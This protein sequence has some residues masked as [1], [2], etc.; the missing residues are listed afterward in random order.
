[1]KIKLNISLAL[2]FGILLAGLFVSASPV[3]A[4]ALKIDTVLVKVLGTGEDARYEPR[5]LQI[6]RGDVIRF[7]VEEGIHTVTAYHP[8]NRRSLRIPAEAESFDSGPLQAGSV[9]FL[10]LKKEGTYD[11]FCLPHEQL[12]HVGRTV[13]GT[14]DNSIKYDDQQLSKTIRNKLKTEDNEEF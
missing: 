14:S 9:W 10:L 12:G 11:Y 13:V 7:E 4:Q 5:H 2:S 3:K 1:M 6:N 8:D